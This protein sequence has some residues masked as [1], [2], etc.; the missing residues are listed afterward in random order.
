MTPKLY[1]PLSLNP[2][3]F[4]VYHSWGDNYTATVDLPEGTLWLTIADLRSRPSTVLKHDVAAGWDY[5]TVHLAIVQHIRTGT[6]PDG[7]VLLPEVPSA[8]F[9][10]PWSLYAAG[11]WSVPLDLIEQGI[12][13]I[14]GRLLTAPIRRV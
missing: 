2:S 5:H 8:G 4:K 12:D 14:Q 11:H 13:D 6:L 1:G 9:S 3:H 10:T 7:M